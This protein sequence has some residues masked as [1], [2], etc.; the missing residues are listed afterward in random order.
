M[1]SKIFFLNK[2][3]SLMNL[4]EDDEI[5]KKKYNV[6]VMTAIIIKGW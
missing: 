3:F 6:I 1:I 5:S 4:N 2:L